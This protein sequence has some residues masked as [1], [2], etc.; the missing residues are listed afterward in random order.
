MRWAVAEMLRGCGWQVSE[1]GDARDTE[2]ALRKASTPFDVV[3]L[4]YLLPDSDD[5]SLLASIR[6]LSPGSKVIMMTAFDSPDMVRDAL[7]LG[8]CTVMEK[9]FDMETVPTIVDQAH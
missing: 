4:D 1:G 9:P 5:L 3:M 7:G 2:A 8:A 6:A